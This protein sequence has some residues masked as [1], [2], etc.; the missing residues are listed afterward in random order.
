MRWHEQGTDLVLECTGRSGPWADLAPYFE[1]GVQKVIV[2]APVVKVLHEAI[3]IERG[4]ITTIH[5]VTNT[6]VLVDTPHKDLHRARSALDS[7]LAEL[8]SLVAAD[9]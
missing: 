1:Q 3:G 6:Q 7:L 8:A 2:A 5:D 4:V 9:L